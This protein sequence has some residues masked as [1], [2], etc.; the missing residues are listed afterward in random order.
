MSDNKKRYEYDDIFSDSSYI[1]INDRKL[2]EKRRRTPVKKKKKSRLPIIAVTCAV[3][4]ICGAVAVSAVSGMFSRKPIAAENEPSD[5]P[6]VSTAA[7]AVSKETSET[8]EKKDELS[9][10]LDAKFNKDFS[11]IPEKKRKV[12]DKEIG[13]GYAVLYDATADKLIY[14]FDGSSKCYPASTTKILT[15]IVSSKI[16]KKDYVITVGDEIK[17]IDWDSSTAGLEVGMKLTYEM[18]LDALLLPSGNDAAYTLA[19]TTARVYKNDPKLSNEKAVKVFAE[20][21]NKAAKEIGC[22]GSHFVCPDGIHDDNHY[23]TAEDL[24]RIAA[25]ARTVPIVMNSCKKSHVEWELI[26]NGHEND[27]KNSKA[28]DDDSEEDTPFDD[29]EYSNHIEWFNSNK[30]INPE[31][32]QYSKYADG[33]K[34]GFT[35]EAGTCLVSSATMNGHTMIAVVMKSE[36]NYNKYRHSN[37]LFQTG[38]KTYNLNY[39]FKNEYVE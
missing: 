27:K 10:V 11:R 17:L 15:A 4:L 38:F 8:S 18:M 32:G 23:T 30:L 2:L 31:S 5:N 14:S 7:P 12:L 28:S 16:L 39:T 9:F 34:T 6:V 1:D 37:L 20:L 29:V 21:M 22:K 35:D 25:Y 26:A 19:V 3:A 13:S 24:A 36:S 33:M